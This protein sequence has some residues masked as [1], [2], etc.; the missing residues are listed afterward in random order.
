MTAKK[1]PG[2][3]W[4]YTGIAVFLLIIGSG[5]HQGIYAKGEETYKGLK[6]L[7]DVIDLIEKNYVD[8]VDTGKLIEKAVQGMV[9]S[10][11]P[12][13]SLLP[14][15]AFKELK[16][17]TQGE[18]TGIGVSI[19]IREG[20][21]VV[22]SPIEGTP[23]YKAGIK[24]GDRI[25]KVDGET[26][27][28][29][30]DAVK[31]MRGPRGT[32]IVVTIIRE[33]QPD[34]IDFK[35][36]RDL[37]PI[38]SVRYARLKPGYG[39]VWVTH[40]R[41]QTAND[42]AAAVQDLEDDTVPL[43]GLILDL[44]GNPGGLLPQAIAVSDQFLDGG[45]ILSIKGRLGKHT[46][47]YAAKP[48]AAPQAYSMAL[49]INGG[50]ASAS[51]IVAGALQDNRRALILGTPSFG[52][53]SVQTVEPLRDGYGLKMTIARYYTPS[54]RSIQAKGIQP[55]IFVKPGIIKK[56]DGREAS[57]GL[58]RESDLKN[59]LE[60][61]PQDENSKAPATRKPKRRKLRSVHGPLDLEKL[62]SDSQV[63][64]ALDILVGHEIF[65]G[66]SN[67]K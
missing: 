56:I 38:Q 45:D 46:K 42:L 33:K 28:D 19:T 2:R 60:A 12:H 34:P 64:R 4:L 24:A 9:D 16:I 58:L 43:K 23:A 17:D 57:E 55:D 62:Q 41:E 50:S 18:F 47:K 7:S 53:G 6:I 3:V 8:S 29:L 22:I 1:I 52:K 25:V 59:H 66:N 37:I 15:D 27:K 5:F 39:Y 44:R 51:E 49:L 10:L 36:V 14:P 11:D 61:E 26:V 20:V 21:I 40:F 63:M 48:L 35:L 67:N 32:D 31:K 13:S 54:G 30:R 65:L